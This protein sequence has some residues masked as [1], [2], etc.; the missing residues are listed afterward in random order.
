[1]TCSTFDV[2]HPKDN[3]KGKKGDY[4]SIGKKRFGTVFYTSQ[5]LDDFLKSNKE[6]M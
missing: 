4:L 6:P 3:C 2:V 1:M 5:M